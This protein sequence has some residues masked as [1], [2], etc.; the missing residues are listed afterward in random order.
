[1]NI[2]RIK[3]DE[4]EFVV[5]GTYYSGSIGTYEQ[6]PEPRQFEIEK[7]ELNGTDVT[8]FLDGCYKRPKY[9]KSFRIVSKTEELEEL[10]LDKF[11]SDGE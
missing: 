4:L 9:K 1:M 6:P 5:T 10:I 8:E 7:V 2:H 3:M 11:Y